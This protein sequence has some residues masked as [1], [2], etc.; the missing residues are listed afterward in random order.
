MGERRSTTSQQKIGGFT[1]PEV[2]IGVALM[3]VFV[4]GSLL[5][6]GMTQRLTVPRTIAIESQ[7]VP[8]APSALCFADA[9]RLHGALMQRLVAAKAVYVFGGS[10][11]AIAPTSTASAVR[12]LSIAGIPNI[13]DFSSGLPLDG[14]T[15]Y[16]RYKTTLG[17]MLTQSNPDDFTVVIIGPNAGG[18][19]VTA[20]AQ[21]RRVDRTITD[22]A[23]SDQYVQRSVTLYDLNGESWSYG[24]L[25]RTAITAAVKVG[26]RHFWYRYDD[27]RVGEEGPVVAVFPDPWIQAGVVG[28]AGVETP[29]FSRFSYVLSPDL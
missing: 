28:G 3:G 10:H 15:F 1:V 4:F 22:G 19:S 23:A 20:L 11:E 24:F 29:P 5:I 9:V 6:I 12:P 8:L 27:G 7:N 25:E 26:A 18:L 14:C 16:Q 17:P 13:S 21:I 2:I